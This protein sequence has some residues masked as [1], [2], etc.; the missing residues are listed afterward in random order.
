VDK[1]TNEVLPVL[2]DKDN[3][4]IDAPRYAVEDLRRAATMVAHRLSSPRRWTCKII[5]IMVGITAY[6]LGYWQQR[7]ELW[8]SRRRGQ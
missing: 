3:H 1:L 7:F 5:I 2:A 6:W 4:T 8:L